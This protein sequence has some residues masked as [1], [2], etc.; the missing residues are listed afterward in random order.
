MIRHPNIHWDFSLHKARIDRD[1][2]KTTLL[3]CMVKARVLEDDC[4]KLNNGWEKTAPATLH[5]GK[6]EDDVCAIK[7]DWSDDGEAN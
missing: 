6:A 5:G 3:D 7:L 2:L 1:N 4:V